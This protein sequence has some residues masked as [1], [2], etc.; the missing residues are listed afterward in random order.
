MR[1]ILMVLSDRL[2]DSEYSAGTVMEELRGKPHVCSSAR[3]SI[4]PLRCVR[5][6]ASTCR[7]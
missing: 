5:S 6:A 7:G 4:L 2:V 1:G 3:N